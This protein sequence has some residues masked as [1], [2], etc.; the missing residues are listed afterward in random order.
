MS[1]T[2]DNTHQTASQEEEFYNETVEDDGLSI[3]V[4]EETD[5]I[6]FSW[7]EDTHPQWNFL[8]NAGKEELIKFMYKQFGVEAAAKE[9]SE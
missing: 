7:N 2:I 3:T 9:E 1:D 4:D 8:K 5:T 6:T